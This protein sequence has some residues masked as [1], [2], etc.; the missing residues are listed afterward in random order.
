MPG[1]MYL[2]AVTLSTSMHLFHAIHLFPERDASECETHVA[3]DSN[4]FHPESAEFGLTP[5]RLYLKAAT[6]VNILALA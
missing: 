6:F 1:W 5:G 4:S 3:P 2:K